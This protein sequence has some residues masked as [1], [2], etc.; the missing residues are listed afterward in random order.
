M[1]P[2]LRTTIII[3][4]VVASFATAMMVAYEMAV[5]RVPRQRAAFESLVRA[6]TGLDVRFNELAFRWGWYGPEAVFRRVEL[7]EPGR[8]NVLLRAPQLVVGINAWQTMRAGQL[9]AGRI[10]L[11]APDIDLA[12]LRRKPAPTAEPPQE[13]LESRSSVLERWKG[14]VIDLQGGTVKVPDP[15]SAASTL[16]LQIRRAALKRDGTEWSGHALVFL[17]ERLGRTARVV[18]QLKG[19]ISSPASLSGGVRFEGVR[20]SFASWR[21]VLGAMP[22]LASNLPQLG[23]G[24]VTFDLTLKSGLVEKA[25]GDV[26]AFDLVVGTPS[27]LEPVQASRSSLKLDYVTGSWQFQRRGETSQLQIEQLVLGRDQKD[28]PLPQFTVEM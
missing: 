11:I 24:D 4:V 2:R 20:L 3:S 7:A 22:R 9:V 23:S 14:G 10:T 5:A 25:A 13:S 12:H 21:G 18:F 15:A 6:Q 16:T 1:I 17:P 8:S 27:W 28:S 26:R 19:D